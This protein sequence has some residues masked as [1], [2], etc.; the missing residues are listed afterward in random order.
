MAALKV[1]SVSYSK[2]SIKVRLLPS[3]MDVHHE[4]KSLSGM[5]LSKGDIV[6]AYFNPTLST[7][8]QYTGTIALPIDGCMNELIPHEVVH[9]VI[10]SLRG[11]H[12]IDGEFVATAVGQ[13][14]ARIFKQIRK[15]GVAA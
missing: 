2:I 1:F 12:C 7:A 5:K 10:H 15:I 11:V 8:A 13:L 6:N 4:F 9:A 3:M 14:C